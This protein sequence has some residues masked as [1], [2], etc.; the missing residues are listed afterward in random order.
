[1]N[2]IQKIPIGVQNAIIDFVNIIFIY[3]NNLLIFKILNFTIIIIIFN[4]LNSYN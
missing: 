3:F 2:V 1:M 4:Q